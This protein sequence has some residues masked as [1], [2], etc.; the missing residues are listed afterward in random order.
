[1]TQD[2][3]DQGDRATA[4]LALKN[5]PATAPSYIPSLFLQNGK[6]GE[7]REQK[8]EDDQLFEPCTLPEAFTGPKR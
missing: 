6:F 5:H 4:T 3:C 8:R 2:R 1:M 7:H